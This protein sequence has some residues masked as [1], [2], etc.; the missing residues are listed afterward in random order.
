[1]RGGATSRRGQSPTPLT[2]PSPRKRGEGFALPFS[3]HGPFSPRAGRRWREAPDEG[4]GD[5]PP[6]PIPAPLTLPSPRK[7]RGEGFAR[8][9]PTR[10]SG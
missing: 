8:H 6:R 7:R 3:P 1:M 2:L 10:G 9:L 5:E 4:R